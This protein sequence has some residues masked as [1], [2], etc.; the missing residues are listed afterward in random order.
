MTVQHP[1]L[2][3][4]RLDARGVGVPAQMAAKEVYGIFALAHP[5]IQSAD[6]SIIP[7][8]PDESVHHQMD[9]LGRTPQEELAS[10]NRRM[11]AMC[12][13]DLARGVRQSLEDAATHID[14]ATQL[15]P[16]AIRSEVMDGTEDAM[17]AAIWAAVAARQD[18][19]RQRAQAMRHP[20]LLEKVT[21]GLRA[22]LSWAPE[23][24]SF[25]KLRN[26][27]EHRGGIVG[28]QDIDEAGAMVLRLPYLKV[29][30][31]GQSG[32]VRPFEIGMALQ[33]RSSME[34]GVDVRTQTFQLGQIVEVEPKQIG[35]MAFACWLFAV[36]LV[37]KLIPAAAPSGQ[38][39]IHI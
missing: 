3:T 30:I 17:V 6:L 35:E 22:P 26:C 7:P 32:S 4:I 10:I 27:L 24:T 25:Q 13:S 38:H 11:A 1:P 12:V 2:V 36:D 33:E 23:L 15:S 21:K 29:E 19:F 28:M 34:V 18:V 39:E 37:D 20:Q 31:V 14:I 16:G 9:L 5:L 8:L